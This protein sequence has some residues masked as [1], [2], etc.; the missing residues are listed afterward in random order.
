MRELLELPVQPELDRPEAFFKRMDEMKRP[1]DSDRRRMTV[2]EFFKLVEE[3]VR[4]NYGLSANL[5]LIRLCEKHMLTHIIHFRN[6][7]CL[8][9]QREANLIL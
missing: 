6:I 9:M 5:D 2:T 7:F 1:L 8:I 4:D 3:R